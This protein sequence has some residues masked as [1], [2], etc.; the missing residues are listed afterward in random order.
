M[1]TNKQMHDLA[2]KYLGIR[3]V[4]AR[5]YCG[6]SKGQPWCDA[7]V[8]WLFHKANASKLFCK[9]TKQTYCPNTIRICRSLYA[10]IPPYLAMP[11]DII[12]FDWDKN[13]NP[14]HIGFVD[15]RVST[16]A[17]KTIEGNTT[18][19]NKKG[20]VVAKSVVARKTRD[21]KYVQAIFRPH[22]SA[23]FSIGTLVIDGKFEY[24]S[25]ANLQKALKI[26]VDGVLGRDT[27]KALQKKAGVKQDGCW[28]KG[29]S[30]AVQKMIGLK[31][32]SID[33]DF[34]PVSVKALQKWINKQNKA[35]KKPAAKHSY[36]IKVNLT[37]QVVTLY[38]NN[39]PIKSEWCSTAKEGKSTPVG[40]W[41]IQRYKAFPAKRRTA[42]MVSGKS[43]AEYIIRFL[44][45]KC[46]HTVPYGKK[47][48][49]GH[50]WSSEFNKLGQRR[51]AGCVR[52][53]W[54]FA[55]YCY[56]H[57][58]I[59]TP[60]IVYRGDVDDYPM[61]KPKKY[62]SVNDIDPTYKK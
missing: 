28:G 42:R 23:T 38:D 21:V 46:Q 5:A 61:G 19:T 47:Q 35:E 49:T 15:S 60:Y 53:P 17:I 30:R 20:Q 14:N 31:G 29:T 34:G 6:L 24:C 10:E 37:N 26:K 11:M 52:V 27:V 48:T 13:G 54:S 40:T 25:I 32:K 16:K 18:K 56:D 2:V 36:K 33:G 55:K 41:K 62:H 59:G 43:Y 7:F 44:G 58:P 4:E 45:H 1:T 8:T 9:G 22:Y 39:K 57:C 3:G 51:S 12:F 50:V